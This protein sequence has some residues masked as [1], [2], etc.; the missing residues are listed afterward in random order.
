MRQ[1][2]AAHLDLAPVKGA[3]RSSFRAALRMA[4]RDISRHKGRSF[5]IVLLIMLPVAGMTGAASLY[6]S[7][8]RTPDEIVRY[9]LGNTQARFGV[10]HVPNGE[11]IQDPLNDAFVVSSSGDFDT[12]FQPTDPADVI[13]DGYEVLQ[14][15][16]LPLTTSVGEALVS[17]QGQQVDALHPAFAGKYT[18]LDGRAPS[19]DREVV[20]SPGL[21][22]RFDLS[23]GDELTTSA[24]TFI[25]VGTIRDADAS[26][27]NSF[28]YLKWDQ[29]PESSGQAGGMSP[30]SYYLVGSA[31]IPWQQVKD[32]NSK[33]VSVLS[34]SVVLDP[35]P[36]EERVVPGAQP[37]GT[38]P[39]VVMVYATFGLIGALAL[40]EVGLLAGAAF[41]VGAKQQV[42]ELALLA[43]SG[44][45]VPTIRAVVTAQGL[46][47]GGLAV[48][49]GAGAGLGAAA[50]VVHWVR[51][52]GSARLAGVHFDALLTPLAMAM[53]LAACILAALAPANSIARQAVLGALKSGRAPAS[54]GRRATVTGAV[55]FL[56]GG[57]LLT[58][59]WLLGESA[60]DPD[61]RAE[62]LP[63]VA[64]LLIGGAVLVVVAL[65]LL[66]GW[67]V[68][69][70]TGRMQGLSLSLRMAARD[71]ARNR[72]R[73]VPAVAAVLAAATLAS[74]ALV[75]SASQQAGLRESHYW[76]GLENQA[77]LPLAVGRPPLAD[78]TAQPPLEVEPDR[79]ASAVTGSINTVAWTKVI[80]G[81]GTV[82][83]CGFGP[84][85]DLTVPARTPTSNCVLYSLARPAGQ[86]C[87]MTPQ[88][89]EMDPDDWRCRGTMAG[90][91]GLDRSIL[92]G[93]AEEIRAVFGREAGAEAASML[94]AGGMVVTNP[95]F[96]RDGKAVLQ[97]GDVRTQRQS[98]SDGSIISDTVSST[99][100]DAVVLE[101][102]VSVPYYGIVSPETAERLDLRPE[103]AGLLVQ[104]SEFPS[105][106]QVDAVSAAVASVYKQPTGAFWVEPG[107]SKGDAWMT[108]SIVAISALVTFSAAGVT[109]GLSLADARTD[110]AT[111]AGVG[112]SPRLRKALAGAQALLTSGLG[113]VLGTIAGAVP[114]VLIAASTDM[115]TAVEVPWL[116]LLALVAAVPLTGSA[117]AWL[118][119]RAELPMSR[120]GLAV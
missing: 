114:V 17:L 4:R 31:P 51:S 27:N 78:G 53:G 45:E 54:S 33:G 60:A 80:T 13:P 107:I 120:R 86:E 23:F 93:G 3:R 113:A 84:D 1:H 65:V 98:P 6:Q 49:T 25:P 16:A 36:M 14:H 2:D 30:T 58:G 68:V 64:T 82:S 108:W 102:I 39:E 96:V 100:L 70:L 110:H 106:S 29:A 44:A 109:T 48:L 119:T 95:V 91:P 115:R 32:A 71:S 92:V 24:G 97:G 99:S 77:F 43:A 87:P 35:P 75:L 38:P 73:T 112:A 105:A 72:G 90:S 88:R 7:S 111:L 5:L 52:T 116:Q 21:L 22:E 67:L 104:L 118:F 18:L 28:L 50:A 8:Q 19:S 81:P 26:D 41:A 94:E 76:Q 79:L 85:A 66:T 55:L 20:V 69:R 12:S 9:E 56:V 62:L 59:G 117:L 103:P 101:P 10:L 83:N 37:S 40:L 47:L 42:R 46:W 89:R 11:S 61:R 15:R 74:A 57:G 63:L 34:R